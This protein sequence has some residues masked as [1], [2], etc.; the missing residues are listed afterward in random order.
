MLKT[1]R[2]FALLILINGVKAKNNDNRDIGPATC[3]VYRREHLMIDIELQDKQKYDYVCEMEVDR[4]HKVAYHLKG[5]DDAFYDT[6]EMGKTRIFIPLAKRGERKKDGRKTLKV[7]RD[8][9]GRTGVTVLKETKSNKLPKIPLKGTSRL[10]VLYSIPPDYKNVAR[11]SAEISDDIFGVGDDPVNAQS[12]IKACSKNQLS[13]I[14]A[15]SLET[16]ACYGDNDIKNGVLE[17]PITQNCGGVS[18][19][20]VVN[21]NTDAAQAILNAKGLSLTND[22]DQIM[23]I[24]PDEVSWGGAAAWAYLPGT[25]SAFKDSY[26]YR[27]GVQVHEFG[28]NMGF[29]H[30]GFGSASYADHSCLMGNPSYNDDGPQLCWNGAKSWESTWYENDSVE[31]DVENGEFFKGSLVG[32][33]DWANGNFDSGKHTVVIKI[34]DDSQSKS[35][36]FVLFN[37]KKGAHGGASWKIDSVHITTGYS[38]KV[39]WHQDALLSGGKYTKADF[40]GSGHS[41]IVEVC[42]INVINSPNEPDTAFVLVYLDNGTNTLDCTIST[43]SPTTSL[44][45]TA[46]LTASPTASPT[47]PAPTESCV[48]VHL[49]LQTDNWPA[50]ISWKLLNVNSGEV[51][52]SRDSYPA[53]PMNTLYNDYNCVQRQC[54]QFI[55]FDSWGDGLSDDDGYFKFYYDGEVKFEDD[56]TENYLEKISDVFGSCGQPTLSPVNSP[57]SSSTNGPTYSSPTVSPTS[58][59]TVSPTFNPSNIPTSNPSNSPTSNT[60]YGPTFNPTVSPTSSPSN[61]PTSSPTNSPT[62]SPTSSPTFSPTNSPTSSPTNSPS[63]IR[64]D[65]PTSSP[66]DSPIK[67][68]PPTQTTSSLCNPGQSL[69]KIEFQTDQNSRQQNFYHLYKKDVSNKFKTKV[70]HV[71]WNKFTNGEPH[72]TEQC[73]DDGECY[74]FTLVDSAGD[75]ICC[76]DGKGYYRITL[77]GKCFCF[78]ISLPLSIHKSSLTLNNIICFQ[79][80]LS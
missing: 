67:S 25:I 44:A 20:T 14:P 41:L 49:E 51:I 69:L 75:G 62:S 55:M 7:L 60:T 56:G 70:L 33:G 45:P 52:W 17:V 1:I 57:P 4:N 35:D 24:L 2:F 59:P 48:D 31:V 27:M 13:V 26:S 61:I 32:V 63:S 54:L 21:Y 30:S 16:D 73:I 6:I 53:S 11:T 43:P 50:D 64:T 28:H 34:P 8:P 15:C 78:I 39:S 79:H 23:H 80:F 5:L 29:H 22:F 46:S 12:Q 40:A 10:L 9:N 36:Y 74:R 66:T 18:S 58:S 37:R 3:A 38:K 72:I 42:E 71:G 76:E 77:D 68:A 65:S 47:T 19:G